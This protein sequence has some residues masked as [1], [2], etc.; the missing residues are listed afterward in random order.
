MGSSHVSIGIGSLHISRGFRDQVMDTSH[1]VTYHHATEIVIAQRSQNVESVFA[2]C[3]WH[4][5]HLKG[6]LL[7]CISLCSYGPWDQN[8]NNIDMI[9]TTTNPCTQDRCCYHMNCDWRHVHHSCFRCI[10]H[11]SWSARFSYTRLL[12]VVLCHSPAR[13][14]CIIDMFL[15]RC[16]IY[17]D[18]CCLPYFACH[19]Q[20]RQD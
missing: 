9:K 20:T 3:R 17:R 12:S 13:G 14:V 11:L 19:L 18:A 10:S 4:L 2:A 16:Y 6:S 7:G 1:C 15:V 8:C 5:L